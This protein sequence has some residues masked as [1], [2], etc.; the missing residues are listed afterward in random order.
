MR[1]EAQGSDSPTTTPADVPGRDDLLRPP[2]AH[3]APATLDE[4]ADPPPPP[5]ST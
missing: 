3:Q 5:G 2:E 1:P 4:A